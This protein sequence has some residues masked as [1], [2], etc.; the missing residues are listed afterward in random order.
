MLGGGG[1]P[2]RKIL[3][4]VREKENIYIQRRNDLSDYRL[5]IQNHRRQ[6]TTE[7]YSL[8]KRKIN[9]K[10]CQPMVFPWWFSS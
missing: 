3:K 9:S 10:N 2:K 4:S 6:K 5:L 7:H 1:E 8:Q